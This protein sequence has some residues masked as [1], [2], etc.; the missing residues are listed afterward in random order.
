[1]SDSHYVTHPFLS[2]LK[3]PFMQCVQTLVIEAANYEFFVV[4]VQTS[5]NV[6]SPPRSAHLTHYYKEFNIPPVIS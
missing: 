1:M 2:T 5:Q 4:P 3:Y 6:I